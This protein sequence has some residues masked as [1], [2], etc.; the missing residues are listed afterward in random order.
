MSLVVFAAGCGVMMHQH[1]QHAG[2]IQYFGLLLFIWSFCTSK[3]YVFEVKCWEVD[4]Y[5]C[6]LVHRELRSTITSAYF[7][8]GGDVSEDMTDPRK[9]ERKSVLSFFF[10]LY[11]YSFSVY[12]Q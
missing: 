7:C 11:K 1:R 6:V 10:L 9:A 12:S 4:I 8:L 2:L 3:K 5:V